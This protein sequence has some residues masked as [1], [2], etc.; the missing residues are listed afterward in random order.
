VKD[1]VIHIFDNSDK[2]PF[3]AKF[4]N[5]SIID[6]TKGQ[7]INFDEWLKNYPDKE[8]TSAKRNHFGSAKHAYSVQK[9]IDL[10]DEGFV[11]L[12]SDVLLKKDISSFFDDKYIFVGAT[13]FWKARTGK[14]AYAKERAI[15]YACFINVR[16]CK[17]HG[18]KYFD[19]KRIYGL[20]QNG[21]NYDTGASFFEEIKRSKLSYKK[22]NISEYIIHYKAGSWVNE[23]REFDGYN[24]V[25]VDV[26]VNQNKKYWYSPPSIDGKKVVY[27]CIT[28]GYDALKDPNYVTD[29]F[30]YICFTD[31]TDIE[32]NVWDIRPLPKECEEL[33]QVKK[34]RY[35]KINAHKVLQDYDIS[36]WVDGCVSLNGD[37]N[38]LLSD[39]ITDNVSVYVP[40]HP[41]RNCTYKESKTVLSLRR[42]AKEIVEPQMK[43]Y[44]EEGFPKDYGLLQSNILIRKHNNEDC[45]RLM[46]A[47]NNEV[48]NGSHRDQLSFNYCCWKNPDIK[49]KY[50]DKHIYKSKWFYWNGIHTKTIS[51][52]FISRNIV[53]KTR[54]YN[55]EKRSSVNCGRLIAARERLNKIL[56]NRRTVHS[57]DVRIY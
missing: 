6:N 33:T 39:V 54:E 55:V 37:L 35:I 12:D 23:A 2:D 21:D 34:Q 20:S 28:G 27:T 43:K 24:R 14:A 17:E 44:M 31:N 52:R 36:I 32:S 53:T 38:K 3:V 8:N 16:K 30:D 10:F 42:D 51:N 57:Y 1:A 45:I 48:M 40:K 19:D 11:L 18:I 26:W 41:Q 7:I 49:V 4:D 47:W 22:S 56:T 9:C 46:E 25:D 29:E 15:P 5:V 13:E 50:L